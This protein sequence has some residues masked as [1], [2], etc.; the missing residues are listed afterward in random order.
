VDKTS[1]QVFSRFVKVVDLTKKK[2]LVG[3][4]LGGTWVRVV[5]SDENG[6]FKERISERVDKSSSRAISRQIIRLAR[7]VCKRQGLNPTALRGVGIASA[8]PLNQEK[9]VLTKPPNLPF[10]CVPLTKPV[11]K[12]LGTPTCLIND[13]AGAALGEKAFGA[14]RGLDNYVYITISTG[15]GCGAVVNGTLLLGKDGNGHEVGHLTIDCAGRLT[16]GC[17]RR[18]HWEAYCSGKNIPNFVRMRLSELDEKTLKGSSLIR[19][20]GVELSSLSASDLFR[21]AKEGDNLSLQLVEEIGVLNAIGF[22][23]VVN[24]YDPSLITVGGTVALKNEKMILSPIK[25]HVGE[26]AI[27]RLP[28]IML[29]PLGEDAGVYGAIAAALEYMS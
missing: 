16:C 6:G 12:E 3:V 7:F 19:K 2:Y 27:N 15:I 4:D 9:G 23:N 21:S 13:C 8:G 28:K 5:L 29:T 26:Y 20:T 14:A 11:A 25:N 22:A 10:E 18:G 24:A 17:G 1:F